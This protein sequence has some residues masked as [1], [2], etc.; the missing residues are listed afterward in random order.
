M[1][2]TIVLLILVILIL[3]S[4]NKTNST[5]QD[6][7]FIYEDFMDIKD[8]LNIQSDYATKIGAFGS[9]YTDF[10]NYIIINENNDID[11]LQHDIVESLNFYFPDNFKFNLDYDFKIEDNEILINV[12]DEIFNNI[13]GRLYKNNNK[14][15]FVLVF[16]KDNVKELYEETFE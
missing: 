12:N 1:K 16:S 3:T 13:Y 10:E 6:F 8:E 15:L 14:Q 7:D 5:N 11:K 9:Y 4:C 2:K